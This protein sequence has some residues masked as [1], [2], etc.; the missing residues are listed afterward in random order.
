M[1]I[2]DRANNHQRSD[3]EGIYSG[4]FLVQSH[5]DFECDICLFSLRNR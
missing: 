5:L 4:F 1:E 3:F 2:I